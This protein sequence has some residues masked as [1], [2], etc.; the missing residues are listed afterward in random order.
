MSIGVIESV[1]R[2]NFLM[3]TLRLTLIVVTVCLVLGAVSQAL[4]LTRYLYDPQGFFG[5]LILWGVPC[6]GLTSF[7]ICRTL[8]W[9]WAT[10]FSLGLVPSLILFSFCFKFTSGLVP[11][12]S[13]VFR[14]V[15]SLTQEGLRRIRKEEVDTGRRSESR[16]KADLSAAHHGAERRREPR[17]KVDLSIAYYGSEGSAIDQSIAYHISNHGFCLWQPKGVVPGDTIKFELRV[18]NAPISG[19]AHI[20]WTSNP[21]TAD[22]K[23][24]PP[25]K[26]GCRIISVTEE[27]E[28]VLRGYLN[29]QH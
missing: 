7:A 29:K 21:P 23:K 15:V 16:R 17:Y 3:L 1:Q 13:T 2:Q 27:D 20:E 6:A 10:S 28:N 11:E 25:A 14:S 26:A 8:N 12:I 9:G 24:A 4:L 5:R 18:E 22:E 19:E